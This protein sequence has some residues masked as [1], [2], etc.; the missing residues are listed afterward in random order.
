MPREEWA[1]KALRALLHPFSQADVAGSIPVARSLFPSLQK[2]E[3]EG[4]RWGAFCKRW[5]KRPF[6]SAICTAE[7]LE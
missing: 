5:R 2:G 3:G 7:Q 4:P 6:M 1:E